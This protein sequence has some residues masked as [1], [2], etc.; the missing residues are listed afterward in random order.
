MDGSIDTQCFFASLH[1]EQG[2]LELIFKKAIL[3]ENLLE[4]ARKT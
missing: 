2:W 1:E 4:A 3:E